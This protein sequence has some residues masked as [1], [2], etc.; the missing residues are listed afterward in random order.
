MMME[1]RE[2]VISPATDAL[3]A[4][5]LVGYHGRVAVNK[6]GVAM[7]IVQMMAQK[8][9]MKPTAIELKRNLANITNCGM[10]FPVPIVSMAFMSSLVNS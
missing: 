8:K 7:M 4:S 10:L 3:I 6:N 5:G 9:A 1:T 2:M